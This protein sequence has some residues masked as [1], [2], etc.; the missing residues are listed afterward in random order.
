[1]TGFRTNVSKI[2]TYFSNGRDGL[3]ENILMQV[4]SNFKNQP[5]PQKNN[6]Q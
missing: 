3:I 6:N 2:K 5:I 4:I 1:V